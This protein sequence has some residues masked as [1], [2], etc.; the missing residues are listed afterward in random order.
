MGVNSS[1]GLCHKNV[2]NLEHL[3]VLGQGTV[4]LGLRL[5]AASLVMD[6]P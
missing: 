3:F 6:S 4:A 2:L 5:I 1:K